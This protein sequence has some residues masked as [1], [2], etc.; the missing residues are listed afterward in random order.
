MPPLRRIALRNGAFGEALTE[1][2][3]SLKIAFDC[4]ARVAA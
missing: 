2:K 4:E 3:G 1:A